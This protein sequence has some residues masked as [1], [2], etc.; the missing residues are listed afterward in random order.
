MSIVAEQTR[1]EGNTLIFRTIPAVGVLALTAF[2]DDATSSDLSASFVKRFRYSS[3]GVQYTEWLSLTPENILGVELDPNGVFVAEVAY[4]MIQPAGADYLEVTEATFTT[5]NQAIDDSLEVYFNN[6]LFKKY[7]NS[8]DPDV[9]NWYINVL[10]KLYGT[11]LL[12]NYISR[13]NTEDFLSFFGSVA[14]FFAFYVKLARVFGSFYN[15]RLLIEDFL[16]QRSLQIA[17]TD[18]L[19]DLQFLMETYYSQMGR[20]GTATILDKKSDGATVNGEF[21]R[22]IH[23]QDID[24][25]LFCLYRKPNFGWNLGNSSPLHRG[26]KINSNLNKAPWSVGELSMANVGPYLTTGATLVDGEVVVGTSGGSIEVTLADA[27]KVDPSLDYQFS[28]KIKLAAT[29]T[30]TFNLAGYDVDDVLVTNIS[31]ASGNATNNFLLNA[32]LSRTDK[33]IE[34]RCY[35]YNK[36]R[37]VFAGDSTNL[38]QGRNIIAAET[39][40]KVIFSVVTNGA[41]NIKDFQIVPMMTSY[42]RGYLQVNN[43]ISA[44]IKNRNNKKSLKELRDFISR[45]L[46][47][48]NTQLS[49]INI[50]DVSYTQTEVETDSTYWVGAGEYCRKVIWIGDDPSCEVQSTIWVPDEDTAICEQE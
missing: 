4:E 16:S 24:E 43:F 2:T 49:L 5:T 25:F 12:A 23:Y 45:N 21:L 3:N 15:N 34:V 39:L 8:S 28:F 32:K 47:P 35:L 42:S 33:Y 46:L 19:E 26:L 17:P 44:W 40:S 9:L 18:T 11:G 14:K 22:T 38:R 27:V 50:G 20:R 29:K 7:F 31:R 6:S 10:E 48:Y 13:E 37:G 30:L 41:A 36:D 1:R